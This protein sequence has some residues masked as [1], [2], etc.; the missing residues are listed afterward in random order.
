MTPLQEWEMEKIMEELESQC[1]TNMQQ[2]IK[3]VEGLGIEYDENVV[4]DVCRS[5]STAWDISAWWVI[6]KLL[7]NLKQIPFVHDKK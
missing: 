5:V 6:Y 1:Y 4:C 3:T 2:M 7:C